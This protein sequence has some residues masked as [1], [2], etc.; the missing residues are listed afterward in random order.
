MKRI[1]GHWSAG[2][3]RASALD[4]KHYHFIV[5]IDGTVVRGDK[6]V[7]ANNNTADGDYAAHTLGTN[8]GAIG[9][10]IAAMAGAVERPFNPGTRPITDAQLRA[11]V[12]LC[13]RLCR[14]YAIPVT[15]QTVLTHA[16]V[17]PTLGI[18]QKGKW[19]IT[20]LPGMEKPGDPVAVGDQLRAWILAKVKVMEDRPAPTASKPT[21]APVQ[22]PKKAPTSKPLWLTGILAALAAAWAKL[23]G[24]W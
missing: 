4:K 23:Q 13:A 18:K 8:T 12:D 10:A 14:D 19:D 22:L 24:W 7:E 1:I 3:Y 5:E 17:Q 16:E 20:W 15:R 9:V 21:Q 11:Y 2:G 6:P